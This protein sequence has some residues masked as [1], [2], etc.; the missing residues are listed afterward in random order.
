M[1]GAPIPP[2][3]RTWKRRLLRQVRR[4]GVVVLV[5]YGVLLVL[6]KS[7]ENS[8][9]YHPSTADEAWLSPPSERVRDVRMT[10]QTGDDIHAWWLPTDDP[11][12]TGAILICHGNGG[13]LSHRGRMMA[14]L[15]NATG[16]PVLIFDYPGYGKSIGKPSEGGCY[17]AGIAAVKWL[18]DQGIPTANVVLLG[19]SLG[20]GVATELATKLPP[21][22]LVLVKTF[23]SLPAAAKW[24]YPWLPTHTLMSNRFDTLFKLP[25]LTCPVFIAHGTADRVVP[26][27]H[28]EELFAAANE[29]KRFLRLEGQDHN[30]WLTADFHTALAEF[31]AR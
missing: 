12:P 1:S 21:R 10:T 16:L 19:E 17:D 26:F 20:G 18:F 7:L 30:A 15:T 13:N 5:L 6:F 29:P 8:L 2:K 31:L 4:F 23:T 25:K 22:A 3:P 14:D 27:K 9:V 24:H 11:K 28:A